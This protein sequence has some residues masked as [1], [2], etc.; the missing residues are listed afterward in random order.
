MKYVT[1]IWGLIRQHPV[2]AAVAL[3][4]QL[5]VLGGI[6]AGGPPLGAAWTEIID[7]AVT[8]AIFAVGGA[9][10]GGKPPTE[11]ETAKRIHEE[12]R[13]KSRAQAMDDGLL[14]R[15][16]IPLRVTLG[17]AGCR[18]LDG[19]DVLQG[20]ATWPTL[21]FRCHAIELLQRIPERRMIIMGERGS[22]KSMLGTMLSLGLLQEGP[23]HVGEIADQANSPIRGPIPLRV[24]ISQWRPAR[25]DFGPWFDRQLAQL[26]PATRLARPPVTA[27]RAR[28]LLSTGNYLP[29]L[30]GLDE[31]PDEERGEAVRQLEGYFQPGVPVVI[32]SRVVPEL[33]NSFAGVAR[34]HI[35]PVTPDAAARYLEHQAARYRVSVAPFTGLLRQG[36]LP[37]LEF[38]LSKPLYLDLADSALRS[39]QVTAEYLARVAADN[40]EAALRNTLMRWRMLPTLRAITTGG[41]RKA[42]YLVYFA[43]QMRQKGPNVLPWWHLVDLVP[44][45]VLVACSGIVATVPSYALGLR[46]PIGLTRGLTIGVVA[47]IAFGML[48]GRKIRC[49]DLYLLA[50][51]QPA[52]ILVEGWLLTSDVRQA[53]A[54]AVEISVAT[55]LAIRYRNALFGPPYRAKGAKR[56]TTHGLIAGDAAGSLWQSLAVLVCIGIATSAAT[57]GISVLLNFHDHDRNSS[58]IFLAAAFGVGI[59]AFGAR[60]MTSGLSRGRMEPSTVLLRVVPRVGGV[61]RA[62]QAGLASAVM[63]GLGGGVGGGVRLGVTYGIMMTIAYGLIIGIP[64]GFAGG[65]IMYLSAPAMGNVWHGGPAGHPAPSTLRTDRITAIAAVTGIGAAAA[66]AIGML[67][68]PLTF[69]TAG[70]DQQSA[71]RIV[72][73]DG[74]L[75]GITIGLVVACLKTAWPTYILAHAWLILLR[76]API[77][78]A[79]FIDELCQAEIFRRQGSYIVFRNYEYQQY[80]IDHGA[81]LIAEFER[82]AIQGSGGDGAEDLILQQQTVTSP[83]E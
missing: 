50:A 54:D 68:G 61:I 22:G 18:A 63:I 41:W 42:R 25:E 49:R 20:P 11:F 32:L 16:F 76:R 39:G 29:I 72:P 60:V 38:L 17:D 9:E 2:K 33:R 7:C 64:V 69:V 66:L 4:C 71:F 36:N 46:M 35:A 45:S 6:A 27:N 8:M 15:E 26:Y 43:A 55:A 12:V 82:P 47:G 57:R 13:S 77:R 48:R 73:A 21:E 80:L 70:I 30:D 67:I 74:I 81:D 83:A 34:L 14:D 24:P 51:T 37:I 79:R 10:G 62:Y 58:T 56:V 5:V 52:A 19:S 3:S 53:A 23:E 31:I 40:D 28:S 75:F 44:A 65:V 1:A 59:A 78:L